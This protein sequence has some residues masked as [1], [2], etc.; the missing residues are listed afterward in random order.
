M[1]AASS[2]GLAS[3]AVV[4]SGVGPQAARKVLALATTGG[5]RFVVHK[6]IDDEDVD[7]AI[8]AFRDLLA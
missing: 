7:R 4:G 8:S 3:G 5:I 2:V 6:D 1:G